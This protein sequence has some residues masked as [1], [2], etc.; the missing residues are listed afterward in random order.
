MNILVVTNLR[1][2]FG[3]SGLNEYVRELGA[4]RV[5]VTMRFLTEDADVEHLLRDA[6]DYARIVAAGGE[7][8]RATAFRCA[9]E[10]LG[11]ALL[12][13]RGRPMHVA[14]SLDLDTWQGETRVALRLKDVAD[15]V[16]GP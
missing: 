10:P 12:A 14:G 2:G 11:R 15:P 7:S 8:L 9:E 1:S 3:D 13:A 16:R 4:H 5:E 6:R